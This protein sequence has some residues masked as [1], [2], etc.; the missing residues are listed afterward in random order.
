MGTLC[1][2]LLFEPKQWHPPA[3]L[4]ALGLALGA[5]PEPAC[6]AMPLARS[7]AVGRSCSKSVQEKNIVHCSKCKTS[8]SNRWSKRYESGQQFLQMQ[9]R[10]N[11]LKDRQNIKE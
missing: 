9:P 6:S 8:W 4:L 5:A 7:L 1:A 10:L 11:Q 3:L 2:L